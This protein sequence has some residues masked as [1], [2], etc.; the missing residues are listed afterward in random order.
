MWGA[1][2]WAVTTPIVGHLTTGRDLGLIFPVA[3]VLMLVGWLVGVQSKGRESGRTGLELSWEYVGP[4]VKNGRLL[5]FLVLAFMFAVGTAS[6]WTFYSVYLSEIGAS[7]QLIGIAFGIQGFSELPFFFFSRAILDRCGIERTLTF[8]FLLMAGRVFFYS[9]T[10]IPALAVAVDV[11]HGMTWSLFLVA[12]VEYVNML[13]PPKLRA[14]GQSLFWAVYFGAGA[15]IGNT[16]AGFLYDRMHIHGMFGVNAWIILT[17]AILAVTL[18]NKSH[19]RVE[20]R[21][22]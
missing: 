4:V 21:K 14:T 20:A 6:V 19:F 1:I 7:R 10:Y 18:F 8:A 3:A 15:I 12:S 5:L 9:W 11:V 22:L 13:V 16:W 2:G 17:A